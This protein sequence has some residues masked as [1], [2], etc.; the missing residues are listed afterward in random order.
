M[1]IHPA[2]LK[3]VVAH[4]QKQSVE[5]S[6]DEGPSDKAAGAA[7]ARA[8]EAGLKSQ[9]VIAASLFENGAYSLVS[10][11]AARRDLER[12]RRG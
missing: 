4:P 10:Y 7:Q 2:F 8:L 11:S 9:R 1:S 3:D 12:S 5:D 6:G